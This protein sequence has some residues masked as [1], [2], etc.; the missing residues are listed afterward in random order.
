MTDRN[1]TILYAIRLPNGR[2]AND[3]LHEERVGGAHAELP[4]G[5]YAYLW[6]DERYARETLANIAGVVKR[7]G[8]TDLFNRHADVVRVR[9]SYEILD[10]EIVEAEVEGLSEP[11]TWKTAQE[12]PYEVRV[13][14]VNGDKGFQWMRDDFD[15]KQFHQFYNGNYD[16]YTATVSL[17]E[18]WPDGFVEVLP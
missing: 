8:L 3:I 14:P 2:L 15:S 12:V 1:D 9:L 13:S 17:T 11:R 5:R 6:S 7:F 10:D 18:S 16:G 4:D